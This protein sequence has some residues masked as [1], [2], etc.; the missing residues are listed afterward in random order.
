MAAALSPRDLP[1][2]QRW[3]A[4]DAEVQALAAHLARIRQASAVLAEAGV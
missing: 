1:L 3:D 2:L 4:E